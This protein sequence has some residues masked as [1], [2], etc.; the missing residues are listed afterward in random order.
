MRQNG[1]TFQSDSSARKSESS[2]AATSIAEDRVRAFL[3]DALKGCREKDR[4][5]IAAELGQRLDRRV[6]KSMLDEC[7]RSAQAG[8]GRGARLP[9]AWVAPL[10]EILGDYDLAR[11]LL[12]ERAQRTLSVGECALEAIETLERALKLAKSAAKSSRGTPLPKS[13]LKRR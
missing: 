6:T 8:E 9:A 11:C 12:P 5:Q 7:T 10:C 4:R 13:N 1:V 2:R 3:A